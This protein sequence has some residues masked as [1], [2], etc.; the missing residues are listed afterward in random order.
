M[1]ERD[2]TSY[3]WKTVNLRSVPKIDTILWISQDQNIGF[4]FLDET[5]IGYT[6]YSDGTTV[7][8]N[9]K[10]PATQGAFFDLIGYSV[11]EAVSSIVSHVL[12]SGNKESNVT[13]A[14]VNIETETT[15]IKHLSTIYE[16][17]DLVRVVYTELSWSD[18]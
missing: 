18:I 11:E 10:S 5:I 3:I 1:A 15:P 7:A 9:L 17:K 14:T 6:S 12:S 8:I 13:L 16:L 2:L 4:R